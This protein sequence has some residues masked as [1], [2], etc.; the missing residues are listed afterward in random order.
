MAETPVLVDRVLQTLA[1]LEL[2][3][4]GR[5]N[6]DA[7]AGPRVTARGRGALGHTEGA[8]ADQADF[9]TALQSASDRVENAVNCACGIGF[10]QAGAVGNGCDQI[11]L[12]QL[13][14]PLLL[15][16]IG[17]G[18]IDYYRDRVFSH[19]LDQVFRHPF[20]S[21]R[22]YVRTHGASIFMPQFSPDFC[23]FRRIFQHSFRARKNALAARGRADFRHLHENGPPDDPAAR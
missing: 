17:L 9:V 16:G 7:F 4:V 1:S 10:G 21:P 23:G 13:K 8:E 11:I 20:E 3:L 18:Q 14:G 6:L 22:V 5:R 2:G 12:V 15:K 19:P